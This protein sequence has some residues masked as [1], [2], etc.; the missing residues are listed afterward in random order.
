M[1]IPRSNTVLLTE[2]NSKTVVTCAKATVQH[3]NQKTT[4]SRMGF[5]VFIVLTGLKLNASIVVNTTHFI[6]KILYIA[7]LLLLLGSMVIQG[8]G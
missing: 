8:L 4:L 3:W 2:S 1:G 6:F 7:F 5:L